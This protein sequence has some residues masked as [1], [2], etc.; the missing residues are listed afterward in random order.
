MVLQV[1]LIVHVPTPGVPSV[2][3]LQLDLTSRFPLE[4]VLRET[5]NTLGSLVTDVTCKVFRLTESSS[6]SHREGLP[7][8]YL[9][10]SVA[11]SHV[12]II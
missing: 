7:A 1:P 9:P 12:S 4:Y 5:Q 10:Y 8:V 3:S 2:Q 11:R 6:S